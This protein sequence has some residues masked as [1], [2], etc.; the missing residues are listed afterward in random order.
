M[1]PLDILIILVVVIFIFIIIYV[2][3]YNRILK[4]KKKFDQSLGQVSINLNR[5]FDILPNI[6]TT[7]GGYIRDEDCII[8]RILY[9]QNQYLATDNINYKLY[10]DEHYTPL[11]IELFNKASQQRELQLNTNF[12]FYQEQIV[13]I[14]NEV[15][16]SKSSYIENAN[17]YKKLISRFPNQTVAKMSGLYVKFLFEEFEI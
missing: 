2:S 17:H 14:N 8:D 6:L 16:E 10:I 13:K 1:N 3:I 4:E 11:L 7:I 9:M 15:S 12:L 5:K